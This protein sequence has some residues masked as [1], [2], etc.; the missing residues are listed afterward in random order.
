MSQDPE[1]LENENVRGVFDEAAE[2]MPYPHQ[3]ARN[4]ADLGDPNQPA[5]RL[6][7]ASGIPK[8]LVFGLAAGLL[9]VA[10][11]AAALIGVGTG[12]QDITV[13]SGPTDS[14]IEADVASD[15]T[16]STTEGKEEEISSTTGTQTTT[17]PPESDQTTAD[18]TDESTVDPLPLPDYVAD[19]ITDPNPIFDGESGRTEITPNEIPDTLPSPANTGLAAGSDLPDQLTP[20]ESFEITEPGV[21]ENLDVDG[22]ILVRADNVTIR[23]SVITATSTYA[24]RLEPGFNNLVVETSRIRSVGPTASAAVFTQGSATLDRVHIT[25]GRTNLRTEAQISLTNSYLAAPFEN[26][27]GSPAGIRITGGSNSEAISNT[28]LGPYQSSSAAVIIQPTQTDISN[29]LIAQ[30]FLSGG[31]STLSVFDGAMDLS[32]SIARDNVFDTDSWVNGPTRTSSGIELIDNL[33]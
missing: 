25:G 11:A 6:N 26:G 31:S 21:Y 22:S 4:L 12:E 20:L 32:D 14:T 3:V 7:S 2:T 23:N 1:E 29:L 27:L 19:S 10:V 5:T 28:I 15:S 9:L 16:D 33:F 24:L 8:R 13:A 30:N 18:T 17:L